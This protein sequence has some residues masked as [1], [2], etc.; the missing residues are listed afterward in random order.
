MIDAVLLAAVAG[1]CF[2]I[3]LAWSGCALAGLWL[4]WRLVNSLAR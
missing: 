3:A 1:I 2:G 4:G